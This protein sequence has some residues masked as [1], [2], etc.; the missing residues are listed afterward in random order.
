MMEA[1][2]QKQPQR[3]WEQL[4]LSYR[5]VKELITVGQSDDRQ[6][7]YPLLD[8][9]LAKSTR[10]KYMIGVVLNRFIEIVTEVGT[11]QEKEAVRKLAFNDGY[12]TLLGELSQLTCI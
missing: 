12:R 5:A 10:E 7:L 6:T 2:I 3:Y 4:R 11:K 9:I 1:Y 8:D